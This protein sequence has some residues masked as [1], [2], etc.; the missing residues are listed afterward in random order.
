[1]EIRQSSYALHHIQSVRDY[2]LV[3]ERF[4]Y[5]FSKS[6]RIANGLLDI[7]LLYNIAKLNASKE[8]I[9]DVGGQFEI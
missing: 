6:K 9:T 5:I 7:I 4:C 3:F 8:G 1:M 2:W